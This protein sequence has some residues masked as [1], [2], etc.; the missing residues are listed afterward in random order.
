MKKNITLAL[1]VLTSSFIF[2]F[3]YE[4]PAWLEDDYKNIFYEE[5]NDSQLKW[6]VTEKGCTINPKE[7]AD[8]IRFN[9]Y[10]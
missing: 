6:L 1:A 4:I 7:I 3:S 5:D 2:G 10:E 8:N 9:S